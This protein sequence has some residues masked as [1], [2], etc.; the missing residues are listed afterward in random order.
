[1]QRVLE[2]EFD[3]IVP[4]HLASPIPEGKQA[5]AECFKFIL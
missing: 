4:A 3:T 1:M 2:W 5:F